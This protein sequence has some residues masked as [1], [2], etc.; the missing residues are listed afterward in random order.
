MIEEIKQIFI[1]IKTIFPV[2]VSIISIVSLVSLWIITFMHIEEF[3][4]PEIPVS[5]ALCS[6]IL[7][8]FWFSNMWF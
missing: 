2:A 7:T 5:L 6:T 4:H 3:E 8:F 1:S